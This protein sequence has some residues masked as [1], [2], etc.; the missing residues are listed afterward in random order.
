METL[1]FGRVPGGLTI[2]PMTPARTLA[3]GLGIPSAL[4]HWMQAMLRAF[5]EL[6]QGVVATPGMFASGRP[7]DW[8][9]QAQAKP[10]PPA[11]DDMAH[12]EPH[13]LQPPHPDMG[14]GRSP[15]EAVAPARDSTISPRVFT[16]CATRKRPTPHA[17][18]GARLTSAARPPS[19]LH[20]AAGG[21]RFRPGRL[22]G[23]PDRPQAHS[24]PRNESVR[25]RAAARPV[26]ARSL[27]PAVT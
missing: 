11:K 8:H 1:F 24:A 10:L 26:R 13:T 22:T 9:T 27:A 3:N 16:T 17:T 15:G 18:T 12:R 20:R 6:V 19:G 23:A 2:A 14:E 7:R 5:V 25:A 21:L 4:H